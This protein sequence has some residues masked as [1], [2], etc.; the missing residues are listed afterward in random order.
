MKGEIISLGEKIANLR[1]KNNFSQ[2]D[3]AERVGV[4]RQT[5]SK[6]ELNETSPD[7]VQAKTLS[8][9]FNISL[10]ELT[11]N[12]INSV[13]VQKVSNTERLA[14]IIL[15]L[16]KIFGIGIAVFT[17]FLFLLFILFRVR[18][19]DREIAGKSRIECALDNEE[20]VYE[21]EYNKNYQVINSGGDSFIANH[22]D[23]LKYDDANVMIAHIEDYFKDH[24]G[25]CNTTVE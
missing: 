2:E 13:L 10:D 22:I 15:K 8:K 18:S 14:G 19:T 3:L 25:S 5:I 23:I 12:D 20:Y 6:W 7:I 1:K 9:I 24:N 4:T 17:L 16:L 21:I 11:S